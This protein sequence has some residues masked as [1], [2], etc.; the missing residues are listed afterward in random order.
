MRCLDPEIF[1]QNVKAKCEALGIKPTRACKESGVGTSFIN[2]I[3]RGQVPS[4]ARVQALA[5]YLG[6]TTS[7]LLGEEIPANGEVG[8]LEQEK[9]EIIEMYDRAAPEVQAAMLAMLRAAE[10]QRKAP[11]VNQA[12]E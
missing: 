11:G 8:G 2:D 5:T 12:E 9:K 6:T 1:V 3:K 4:V 10:A 7:E